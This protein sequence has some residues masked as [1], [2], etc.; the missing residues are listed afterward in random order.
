MPDKSFEI[1]IPFV[2]T[3]DDGW[4]PI[5][6]VLFYTKDIVPI[7]FPLEF[8]TGADT[9]CLDMDSCEWAFS[10]F[11]LQPQ[12][13][14]GIGSKRSRPGKTTNGKISLLGRDIECEILFAKMEYKT[15]RQGV[16]GRECFKI[17]GFG[18]WESSRELYVTLKL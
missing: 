8:D 1:T 2:E 16:I 14:N 10:G 5:I 11:D 3:E 17:F 9:I 12:Q 15:W 4:H 7:T 6:E 18:F 13:I